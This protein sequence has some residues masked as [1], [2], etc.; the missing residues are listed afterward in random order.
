MDSRHGKSRVG[1]MFGRYELQSL[2]GAGGMGEVYRAYDTVKDRSVAL[3]LLRPEFATDDR[4]IERFRRESKLA[5]R[6]QEPHIIPVHDWGEINGVLYIDMRLVDGRTLGDLLEAEGPLAPPRA[7]SIANQV[8]GALDAAHAAGLIHRDIKPDNVLLTAN[9]FAYLVDFGIAHL[10][11]DTGLTS[12]GSAIGSLA[13]M[14]PERF[15]GPAGPAAD[16]YSLACLLYE[17][18]TGHT[19]FPPGDAL[20]LMAAHTM[21]RPTP[22]SLTRPELTRD[23]DDVIAHGME[24]RPELR[25]ASAGELARAATAAASPGRPAGATRPDQATSTR[26]FSQRWPNPEG[27][28]YT[29]YKDHVE[30]AEAPPA[31]NSFGRGPLILAVASGL[32]LLAALVVVFA[33]I[34]RDRNGERN[35][36]SPQ[37]PTTP[38]YAPALTATATAQLRPSNLPGTDNLGW[39]SYPGARCDPGTQPALMART[40]QSALVVCQIQPG[41]F[42]YRGVRISDGASIELANAVRSSQGFDVT[43]PTDGTRYQIRPTSLTIA[44]ATGQASSE[45][46]LA[47]AAAD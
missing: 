13:Y 14:A 10:G 44:P 36:T 33:V 16:V 45:P 12:A 39:T 47:Y 20:Q 28:D 2:L 46:M 1:T 38:A 17:C 11:G 26:E 29:P 4:F 34:V 40:T 7:T 18:L 21:R 9:D 35:G 22:P 3:K 5:A 31:G 6:L 30:P 19:P 42:Y 27:S 37:S 41:N 8:A 32:I 23:F 25:F 43:N 24:K 15:T